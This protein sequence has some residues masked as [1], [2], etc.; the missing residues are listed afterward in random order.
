MS[1]TRGGAIAEALL[2]TVL[3][4]SSWVLIRRGFEHGLPPLSFAG[5]RY[6]LAAVILLAVVVAARSTRRELAGLRGGA[7]GRLALLG[8]IY[9]AGA[10]GAQFVAL[11]M[12]PAATLSMVLNFTPAVV[13]LASVVSLEP[14]ERGQMGGI[15]LAMLGVLVYFAPGQAGIEAVGAAGLIVAVVAL[16]TNAAGSV[17]GR[18]LALDRVASPIVITAVSMAIG[19]TILLTAGL[20]RSGLPQPSPA[21]WAIVGWLALI[22]T[23]VAF[24]L[25][26]RALR[27]LTAVEASVINGT[28]LPQIALL[29]WVFL[30]EP[31]S[32]RQIIGLVMVGLGTLIV[33]LRRR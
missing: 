33:Q 18:R 15:A 14:P 30:A 21:G 17:L 7:W 27:R 9:T 32:P 26:N 11:E 4:S 28:M 29:G 31:L 16:L 23:A 13:A 8:L 19:A 3:W 22:N 24:T 6:S 1:A 12:L 5:V 10:Q 2:V 25:W 20:W